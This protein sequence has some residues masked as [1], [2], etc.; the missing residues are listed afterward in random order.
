MDALRANVIDKTLKSNT[1]TSRIYCGTFPCDKLKH[2]KLPFSRPCGLIVNFDRSTEPGS[3][4]IA[5]F[6]DKDKNVDYFDT[7]ARPIKTNKEINRFIQLNGNERVRFLT[8]ASIQDDNSSVCG[9]YTILFLLCR[10]KQISFTQFVNTFSD[11]L[12]SG[13]YD[14]V[15]KK[16]VN[17]LIDMHKMCAE[18]NIC[19]TCYCDPNQACTVK[20]ECCSK[21]H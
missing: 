4:W 11:Q 7:Y 2:F 6:F 16:I 21:L 13:N 19:I 1:F 17:E 3:H 9:H 12:F 8:G 10:A 20:H 18:N 5:L 14:M 15:V